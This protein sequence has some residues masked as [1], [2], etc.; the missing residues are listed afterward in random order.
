MS[1]PVCHAK[2]RPV[3][4]VTL[5]SLL[6][7]EAQG[8]ASSPDG[9][10][11]C[12]NQ[13]CEMAYYQEENGVRFTKDDVRVRIGMK[14]TEA[15]RPVCYCFEHTIEEIEAQVSLSDLMPTLLDYA[16]IEA[17]HSVHGRSLRPA[18]EGARFASRPAISTLYIPSPGKQGRLHHHLLQT[19]RTPEAKLLRH[20]KVSDAG[21]VRVPRRL[22]PRLCFAH[23]PTDRAEATC[24]DSAASAR[25]R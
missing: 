6:R 18:I 24:N 21:R 2:G 1:C 5:E 15:P 17:P 3:Q 20:V 12:P 14:E 22:R 4:A 9:F 25:A 19:V 8:R 7:D 10:R 16:G 11:Y 23:S 13:S